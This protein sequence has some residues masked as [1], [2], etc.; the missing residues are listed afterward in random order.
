MDHLPSG[1]LAWSSVW[2]AFGLSIFSVSAGP[3]QVCKDGFIQHA[4]DYP[5]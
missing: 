2:I 3:G 5:E 4:G 1:S